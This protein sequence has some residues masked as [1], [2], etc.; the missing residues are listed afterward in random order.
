MENSIEFR[1]IVKI[2]NLK[3]DLTLNSNIWVG[4]AKIGFRNRPSIEEAKKILSNYFGE[5]VVENGPTPKHLKRSLSQW[6]NYHPFQHVRENDQP[7]FMKRKDGE[8]VVAVIWPWRE[9]KG[10]ASLMLYKGDWLE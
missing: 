8:I 4:H 6:E 5:L 10:I 7:L 3:N 2:F 1:K 9:K